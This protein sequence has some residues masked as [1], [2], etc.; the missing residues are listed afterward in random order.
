VSAAN[1]AAL[2]QLRDQVNAQIDALL[3]DAPAAPEA[4]A[5]ATKPH[6]I[7]ADWMRMKNFAAAFGYSPKTI[8]QWCKLGMPHIGKGHY[9]RIDVRAAKKWLE[10]GGP[11]RAARLM[12][13][14]AHL[15]SV[16]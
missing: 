13:A 16:R 11:T 7:V 9:C 5:Q 1:R 10:E 14:H 3:D 2:V 15:R 12:G 6:S 4:P 8:S